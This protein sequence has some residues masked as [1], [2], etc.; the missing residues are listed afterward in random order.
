MRLISILFV[1]ALMTSCNDSIRSRST[2]SQSSTTNAYTAK[3]APKAGIVSNTYRTSNIEEFTQEGDDFE[4]VKKTQSAF[5]KMIV[6]KVEGNNVYKLYE[7][8]TG[9]STSERKVQLE[10]IDL[11]AELKSLVKKN[12][13][14]IT[15]SAIRINM[16]YDSTERTEPQ[17][18]NNMMI[19]YDSQSEYEAIF[20]TNRPFC[21]FRSVLTTNNNLYIDG[22]FKETAVTEIWE[23]STCGTELSSEQ[24]QA[25][26][27]SSVNFCNMITKQKC[28]V[29]NLNSLVK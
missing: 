29:N 28:E 11:N 23:N 3:L 13:A 16:N 18:F 4:V 20:S 21:E 9:Q 17:F 15:N 27:L 19:S 10:Y 24:L 1:T 12:E 2:I 7:T 22:N 8:R 5:V 25:L 6:L 26:D 14:E